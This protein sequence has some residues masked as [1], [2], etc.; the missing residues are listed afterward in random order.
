MTEPVVDLV[1]LAH[2][3][4]K[5]SAVVTHTALQTALDNAHLP[6]RIVVVEGNPE[7]SHPD[8]DVTLHLPGP[9]NFN[10]AANVAIRTGTARWIVVA[11][12]DLVFGPDWLAPLIEADYPIVSARCPIDIRQ[13]D[14]RRNTIGDRVGHHLS[15]WCY[16]MARD[17]YEKIGGLDEE[18]T[19]WC[20]DDVV[21]EQCREHGVLPMIVPASSVTHL[22]S[23][24]LN[25]HPD[26]DDL[27]W[28]QVDAFI[29]R[30]GRHRCMRD[31][32]YLAWK[33]RQ[34]R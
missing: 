18:F 6:L 2:T 7:V 20:A 5:H 1:M 22:G 26:Y 25:T 17:F 21:V 28:A 8:A 27:T 29:T 19:F 15:G 23:Y 13:R 9:F 31:P 4:D 14:T 3:I 30:F 11:N 24:T 12:N 32:R 34:P 33:A 16:M 10:R